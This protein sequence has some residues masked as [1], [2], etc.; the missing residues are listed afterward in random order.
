MLPLRSVQ[1][2]CARRSRP[3][4]VA[5][6]SALREVSFWGRSVWPAVWSSQ[7]GRRLLRGRV[8]T[9][10]PGRLPGTMASRGRKR[11]A[12]AAVVAAAEKQEKLAGGQKEV[13]AATV[14]IEHW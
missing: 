8:S 12:E 2:G 11:K 7:R 1:G 9:L 14:V 6:L 3:D 13:E 5:T 10:F 4:H